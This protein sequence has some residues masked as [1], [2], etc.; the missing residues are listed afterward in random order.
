MGVGVMWVREKGNECCSFGDCHDGRSD[1]C[2]EKCRAGGISLGVPVDNLEY[3]YIH[4]LLGE[5]LGARK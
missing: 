2:P 1:I 5:K 3:I 4:S